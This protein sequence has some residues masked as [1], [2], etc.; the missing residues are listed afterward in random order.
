[1]DS[2]KNLVLAT[3]DKKGEVFASVENDG[4]KYIPVYKETG[5]AG[6]VY[7]SPQF[8]LVL[9]DILT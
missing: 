2:N 4:E 8:V 5:L 3:I 7:G 9:I 1:M 6:A